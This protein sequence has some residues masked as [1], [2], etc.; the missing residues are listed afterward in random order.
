VFSKCG[1]GGEVK[2]D[3]DSELE[4]VQ[5]QAC[6]STSP[7]VPHLGNSAC[8]LLKNRELTEGRGS[9]IAS[10]PL[11]YNMGQMTTLF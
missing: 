9:N 1:T 5:W 2:N 4:F 3:A 8:L 7:P 10:E 6:K 11:M